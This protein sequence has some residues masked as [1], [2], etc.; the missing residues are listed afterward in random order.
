MLAC[1]KLFLSADAAQEKEKEKNGVA[2]WCFKVS[3]P[4]IKQ[5]LGW[6][7]FASPNLTKTFYFLVKITD[8]RQVPELQCKVLTLNQ[9]KCQ[10]CYFLC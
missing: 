4:Y 7:F 9:F 8:C 2:R 1:K 10:V 5:F 3:R 6:N